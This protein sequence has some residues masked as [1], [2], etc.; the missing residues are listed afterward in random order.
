M[1]K[2]IG[3]LFELIDKKAEDSKMPTFSGGPEEF[4]TEL[5]HISSQ[6]EDLRQ[7]LGCDVTYQHEPEQVETQKALANALSEVGNAI[8][9]WKKLLDKED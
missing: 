5:T 7:T 8:E 1:N 2:K 9:A 3:W 4:M 6:L